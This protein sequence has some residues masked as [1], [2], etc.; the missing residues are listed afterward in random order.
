MAFFRQYSARFAEIS[1]QR[2]QLNDDIK[3]ITS[4]QGHLAVG[5]HQIGLARRQREVAQLAGLVESGEAVQESPWS[6]ADRAA[7]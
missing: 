5:Q 2:L 1:R 6:C 4:A 3:H 7:A